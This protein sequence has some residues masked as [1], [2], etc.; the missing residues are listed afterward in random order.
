MGSV[1]KALEG[2]TLQVILHFWVAVEPHFQ[3]FFTFNQILV[4]ISRGFE[5]QILLCL[6]RF[7]VLELKRNSIGDK[8]HRVA[9][10]GA[11]AIDLLVKLYLNVTCIRDMVPL[12][13]FA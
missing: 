11:L 12:S 5:S 3:T 6:L 1:P 8:K 7:E 13:V 10:R 2:E 9:A 4:N